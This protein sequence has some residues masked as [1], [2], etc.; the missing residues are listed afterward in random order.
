MG[1]GWGCCGGEGWGYGGYISHKYIS[2]NFTAPNGSCFALVLITFFH[3]QEMIILDE[4]TINLHDGKTMY[5][6]DTQQYN[7]ARK[8]DAFLTICLYSEFCYLDNSHFS[9]RILK[10]KSL[11]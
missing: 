2:H 4:L 9:H 8:Q 10:V 6:S 3:I 11:I 5:R 7:D 1:V